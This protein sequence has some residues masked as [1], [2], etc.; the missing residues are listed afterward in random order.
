MLKEWAFPAEARPRNAQAGSV[1]GS[2]SLIFRRQ[3]LVR[4]LPALLPPLERLARRRSMLRRPALIALATAIALGLGATSVLSQGASGKVAML[5][6]GSVNDQSWNAAGYAGLQKL[7]EKGQEIAYSENVQAADHVE[8]MK[9]YARRGFS[10]II[11]HSGRFL[12]AAQRVGPDFGKTIFFVGSGSGGQANV[13]SLD[14]ANEQYSYAVGVLAG[15]MTKTGKVGAVAGLEGLPNMIASMGG[16]RLGVK[17]VRPEAEVKIIYLQSMEDPA[18]AKE[19]TFSLVA[20]GADVVSGKLNAG[21]AGIIQAAKEKNVFATGRSVGHTTIAPERVL[22]NID[23]KWSDI[24]AAAVTDLRAG[25]LSGH[26]IAYGFNTPTGGAELRYSADRAL[27]PAVPPAVAAEL[28]TVKK[29]LASGE[30]KVKP[31][32]DDARGGA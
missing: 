31:T 20:A 14:V 28:E 23:E 30:I 32:K 17:S 13:I 24:Y 22:T 29:K 8:A 21:H 1:V 7:K 5:L 25:K 16:F 15:K 11:G 27:N 3:T 6:P 18:A 10:P 4:R 26:Y 19:A 9:D 12:S 2:I